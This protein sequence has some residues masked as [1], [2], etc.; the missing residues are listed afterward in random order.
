MPHAGAFGFEVFFVVGVRGQ[1]D[2]ELLDDF[3][4]VAFEA[5]DF[6]G[7]VGEQAD[8]AQAEIAEDL[9]AH[10]VVPQVGG[11]AEFFVGLDGVESLFLKF[12]GVDFSG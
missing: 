3:E 7:V 5:D 6:F 11:E 1:A 4:A 10:A 2:G 8:A 9:G 12:V